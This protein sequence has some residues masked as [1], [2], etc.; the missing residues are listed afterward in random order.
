MEAHGCIGEHADEL[1][2]KGTEMTDRFVA[3]MRD[4]QVVHDTRL[5]GDF[6]KIYCRGNHGGVER[7]ALTSDAATLG[8][9]GRRPPVVCDDCGE[10]LRYAEK[11]RAFCPLD[12]KPFCSYCETHC[13]EP[14]MR[15]HMR[16]V[17]R[18]AGPRAIVRG[19]ALDS[20]KHLAEGRRARRAAAARQERD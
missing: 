17:M 11:R 6:A 7:H 13:Y 4:R 10:L 18:Y 2:A 3:R 15:E 9:Y 14:D 16:E 20:I 1:R 19:H 12:P 8:V 5:L